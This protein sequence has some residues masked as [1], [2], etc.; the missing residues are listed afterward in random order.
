MMSNKSNK[1]SDNPRWI[2]TGICENGLGVYCVQSN[3]L[4]SLP[5]KQQA[6]RTSKLSDPLRAFSALTLEE[7]FNGVC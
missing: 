3:V 2:E 6:Y 1:G 4:L 5:K 7:S